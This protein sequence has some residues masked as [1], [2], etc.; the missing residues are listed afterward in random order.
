MDSESQVMDSIV[1]DNNL[2]EN[3]DAETPDLNFDDVT[4]EGTEELEE[5]ENENENQKKTSDETE[6][7]KYF[8]S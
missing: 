6:S 1:S 3:F 2:E 8:S 7:G 4:E 5:T